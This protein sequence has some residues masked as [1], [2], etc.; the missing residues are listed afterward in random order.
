MEGGK[1]EGPGPLLR[2][3]VQRRRVREELMTEPIAVCGLEGVD[4]I[5]GR[6]MYCQGCR[7][8]RAVHWSADCPI[9]VCC[10]DERGLQ[11]CS[12]CDAFPCAR[13]TDRAREN[14]RYTAALQR[15]EEMR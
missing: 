13:L 8:D 5:I 14:A 10:V 12:A 3:S 4:E 15:L 1:P 2:G 7:G 6:G 11:S 9:L